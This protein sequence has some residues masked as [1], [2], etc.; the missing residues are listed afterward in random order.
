MPKHVPELPGVEPSSFPF[1]KVVEANGFVFLA[2]QVGDEPGTP[3][4]VAGGITAE[5][6]AT[7][8][9]IGRLLRAVGLDFADVVRVTVFIVDFDEFGAMNDG[10]PRI[11]RRTLSGEGHGR[12]HPSRLDVPGRD[13]RDGGPL[14][15]EPPSGVGLRTRR[16]TCRWRRSCCPWSP[17]PRSSGCG[18]RPPPTASCRGLCAR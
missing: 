8:E 14:E 17:A 12:R 13:G 7:L 16:G 18:H 2:G 6:R 10:L 4:P 9:N 11:L 5:T 1:S 15:R 3:G